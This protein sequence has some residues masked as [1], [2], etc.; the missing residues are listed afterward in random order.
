MNSVGIA[1]IATVIIGIITT[2]SAYL[3]K[4]NTKYKKLNEKY[5]ENVLIPY[6]A[7]YKKNENINSVKYIKSNYDCKD[8]YI[9]PYIFYLV[10]NNKKEDLKKVLIEDYKKCF[11][12]EL[13][14]FKNTFHK[15][16]NILSMIS[17]IFFFC[18]MYLAIYEIT[19]KV[20]EL[21]SSFKVENWN[22]ILIC[23]SIYIIMIIISMFFI[24]L[25]LLFLKYSVINSI[26]IRDRYINEI[27]Y[28]EKQINSKIKEYERNY[29]KDYIK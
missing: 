12:S 1:Q 15:L 6:I 5:L 14:C 29:K 2:A 23:F 3:N 24:F 28:I 11:Y 19:T 8:Y 4:E 17:V 7:S 27:K 26:K 22:D 20:S 21:T 13:N 9:P 16:E 25:Y 10:D 18:I